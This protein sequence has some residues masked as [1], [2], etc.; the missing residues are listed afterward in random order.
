MTLKSMTG[1]A[2]AEGVHGDTSWS[3]EARSVN[4]RNLDLRLRLPSGFEALEIRARG[5]CQEKLSRGNCTINLAVKREGKQTEIRLNEAALAQAQEVA[6][7]AQS[8]TKLNA[9][10]LD[11]LLAMRG[12]VEA[13]EAEESEEAQ[14]ALFHALI[15]GL[16]SA[17]DQLVA[18]RTSEGERL[19]RVIE[20][21]LATI[22]SLVE[23]ASNASAR[24]PEAI[25]SRLA[26]QI[27]RLTEGPSV[28]DPDRLHQEALLLAAKA[29][30]QE[31][32]DRLRAHV[33][34]ANE[35]IES[36]QPVGR[37]FEFLAQE[38]NREANTLCSKASDIEISRA[39]LGLKTVIDQLR[40]QVQNIE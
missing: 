30:I 18:A 31:E 40:E 24:Q 10:C 29:D 34:A 8:L 13:V 28:L 19:Q 17:L 32:L 39:G 27:A 36:D 26:E 2:R 22:D 33:A 37:K 4:G 12:V 3:W 7:R 5:L 15:A 25:A 16:A 9:A 14:A 35:L 6:E 38:F 23:R 21:Q 20:K 11:T 1:F